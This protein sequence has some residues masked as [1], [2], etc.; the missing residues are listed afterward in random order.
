MSSELSLYFTGIFLSFFVQVA[1]AYLACSLLSRVLSRPGQRF[2]IWTAFL[3]AAAAYWFALAAWNMRFF[4]PAL[5]GRAPADSASGAAIAQPFLVPLAWSHSILI[6]CEI[7]AGSYIG[8]VLLL[9]TASLWRRLR[10]RLVLRH[11][12]RASSALVDTFET[13]CRDL[14]ISRCDL[15]VLPGITSPATVGWLRPRVLLP[16]VCEEIGAVPRLADVLR[17]ELAHVS[18]RDYLWAGLSELFCHLLFFHPAAWRARK[19]M[20]LERELA[21][22]CAV[23][24]ARPDRRAD[25]AD[26]L[27]YFVRLRML[28]DK[29]E[30]GLDFAA[31]ASNLGRRVRL[32][33]AGPTRLPWWNRA[34]RAIGGLVVMGAFAIVLPLL[35]VLLAFARP[36]PLSA[37]ASPQ[38]AKVTRVRHRVSA[39]PEAGA[40]PVQQISRIQALSPVREISEHSS[41]AGRSGGSELGTS[42]RPWR[43]FD[44]AQRRSTVSD[45]VL[46]AVT[47]LR[48]PIADHDHDHERNGRL[49]H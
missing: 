15:I 41:I 32:I 28:E 17:H 25:Y 13:T 12:H 24:E 42:D 47:I 11:G 35:T 22:D 26:S 30:I 20:F 39:Q 27:A 45:V 44:P 9:A 36:L 2:A 31:S 5:A 23:V 7:L 46:D 16:E 8:T 1:A 14:G 29:A 40:A 18:R 49:S 3:A 19:L 37:P 33:L 38:T 34:S 4:M 48:G 43:E 6:A 10:L 21:C